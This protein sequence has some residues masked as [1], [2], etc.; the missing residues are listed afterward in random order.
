MLSEKPSGSSEHGKRIRQEAI[1]VV[2]S[3]PVPLVLSF[4][5][6]RLIPSL[7][8]VSLRPSWS[9]ELVLMCE[10]M[11]AESSS[12]PCWRR[13][14]VSAPAAALRAHGDTEGTWGHCQHRSCPLCLGPSHLCCTHPR[15]LTCLLTH[16][17]PTAFP[18]PPRPTIVVLGSCLKQT[19]GS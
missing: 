19:T 9:P 17:G 11:H 7:A 15:E 2:L 8:P 16:P 4:P 12:S 1:E 10:L 3:V 14:G 5:G 13:W 18:C 6:H